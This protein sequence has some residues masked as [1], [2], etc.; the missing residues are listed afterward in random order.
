MMKRWIP[1]FLLLVFLSAPLYADSLDG[2]TTLP[3]MGRM[4][5]VIGRGLLN[6]VSAPI[7]VV[8]AGPRE[9]KRHPK[10]WPFTIIFR[11]FYNLFIREAS[12]CYDVLIYPF[13]VPFTDD[14]SPLTEPMNLPEYPW[15]E[16]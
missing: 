6:V 8:W 16:I 2:R 10:A 13:V 15:K 9:A 5:T 1:F 14:I 3:P 12:G 7:E 4:K 11:S